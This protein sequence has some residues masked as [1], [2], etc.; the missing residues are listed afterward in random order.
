[1]D[2]LP[3]ASGLQSVD[4]KKQYT[5]AAYTATHRWPQF[6]KA[7]FDEPFNGTLGPGAY[8]VKSFCPQVLNDLT[9]EG[10]RYYMEPWVDY[11][12]NVTYRISGL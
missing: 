12:L 8:F 2:T 6:D 4:V 5:T 11:H 3:D 9:W 1:M 10:P 7:D